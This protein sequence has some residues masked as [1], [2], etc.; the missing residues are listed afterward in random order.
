MLQICGNEN[1]SHLWPHGYVLKVMNS[2]D[3]QKL[4][5]VE[6][7]TEL[8][9]YLGKI[10]QLITR[11]SVVTLSRQ[12]SHMFWAFFRS[13]R[14]KLPT[15]CQEPLRKVLLGGGSDP[16]R[17]VPLLGHSLCNADV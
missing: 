3:S 8:A 9:L 13:S 1:E 14:N 5:L 10:L 2:I 15:A 16:E 4:S 6:A 12:N 17:L 11:H 7:Q